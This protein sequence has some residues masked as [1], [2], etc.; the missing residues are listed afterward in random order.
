MSS[1]RSVVWLFLVLYSAALAQ[2]P[3]KHVPDN[4]T[5]QWVVYL[6]RSGEQFDPARVALMQDGSTITGTL[7]ELKLAGT[8]HGNTADLTA[9]RPDGKTFGSVEISVAGTELTGVLRRGS[10]ETP[11]N[12]HRIGGQGITPQT[13]TFQPTAYFRIFSSTLQPVLH[14]N[15]GDTVK[16]TTVDAGGFD[17]K[18]ISRSLGGN[19]QTGP[20]YVEGSLP[21][22]TLAITV[23]RIHLNRDSAAS[24]SQIMPVA[25]TADYYRDA[26]F[27][28]AVSGNWKLDLEH[29]TASLASPTARLKNFKVELKPMLGCVAVAPG[30]NASFRTAWLGP[31]GGNMDYHGIQEG[32]TVYLPV[33]QEGALLYLGDAHALQA[34]GELNG[35]ALETSA[36]VEFTVNVLPGISTSGPRAENDEYL[37]SMGIAGSLDAALKQA[38][39]QLAE[40]IEKDYKLTPNEAAI[41]LGTSVQYEVAEVVDP[42]VNVV[43]KIRKAVLAQIPK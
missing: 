18:G 13:H 15:P 2:E 29:G 8:I 32:V 40:W 1:S 10:V 12:M 31:W 28:D 33:G 34:D 11:L 21:G 7:N 17:G 20:F 42:Q 3:V 41:V 23:K 27:D 26:K 4:L 37:M 36:E 22:D 5:G 35:D 14:I 25:L 38:T 39:T 43:A 9:T 24:G 30:N 6:L 16:T 19:P